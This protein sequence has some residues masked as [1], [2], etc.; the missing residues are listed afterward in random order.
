MIRT[1]KQILKKIEIL[2]KKL[3]KK[4][5]L[6]ENFGDKE[7]RQLDDFIGDIWSD[8]DYSI[9]QRIFLLVKNFNNWCSTYTIY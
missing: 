7:Q 1:E 2:K 8:Y 6:C 9:R 5:K 3:S 4:K